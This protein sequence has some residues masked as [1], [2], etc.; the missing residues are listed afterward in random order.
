MEHIPRST[1][2]YLDHSRESLARLRPDQRA[3]AD[4]LISYMCGTSFGTAILPVPFTQKVEF[5]PDV[6]SP[7]S[8]VVHIGK[9]RLSIH[10]NAKRLL[11]SAKGR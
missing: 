6:L 2:S 4:A 7:Q 11:V 10:R 1:I 5:H 3:D 8:A 9:V